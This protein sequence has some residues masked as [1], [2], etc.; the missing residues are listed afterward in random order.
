MRAISLLVD[1]VFRCSAI[2]RSLPRMDECISLGNGEVF[3]VLEVVH[4]WD[5]SRIENC[6]IIEVYTEEVESPGRPS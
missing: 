6:E 5:E 3:R 2:R 1:G 4:K